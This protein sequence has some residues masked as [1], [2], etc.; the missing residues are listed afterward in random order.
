MWS[1]VATTVITNTVISYI[2]QWSVPQLQW[3]Q[4]CSWPHRY[5]WPTHGRCSVQEHFCQLASHPLV[6]GPRSSAST[7]H[8]A[9]ATPQL[10]M[11]CSHCHLAL[12]LDSLVGWRSEE[13][14]AVL[15]ESMRKDRGWQKR[16]RVKMKRKKERSNKRGRWKWTLFEEISNTK[17]S[18]W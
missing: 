8:K 14:P 3:C 9:W 15:G 17:G 10:R 11:L 6:S 2:W 7:W 12:S 16:A 18:T 13:A 5:S 4:G 1:K